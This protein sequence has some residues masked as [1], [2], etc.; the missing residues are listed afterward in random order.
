MRLCFLSLVEVI[1]INEIN[2][3]QIFNIHLKK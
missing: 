1:E 3:N 2:Q